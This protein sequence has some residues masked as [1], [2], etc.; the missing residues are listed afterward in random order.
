MSTRHQLKEISA[1]PSPSVIEYSRDG[2]LETIT[3]NPDKGA[4]IRTRSDGKPFNPS[5]L[6]AS[7]KMKELGI[8]EFRKS[9]DSALIATDADKIQGTVGHFLLS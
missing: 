5:R 3:Y 4:Y 9:D 8:K 7:A 2:V 1:K 6:K